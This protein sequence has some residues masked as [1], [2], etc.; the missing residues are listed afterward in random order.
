VVADQLFV[1]DGPLD[2]EIFGMCGYETTFEYS[3][4]DAEGD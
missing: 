1:E 4:N 2:F 3:S